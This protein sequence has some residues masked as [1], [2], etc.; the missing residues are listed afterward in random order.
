MAAMAC[1]AALAGA[2]SQAAGGAAVAAAAAASERGPAPGAAVA[3]LVWP[4]AGGR[5]LATG[6][7]G[8]KAVLLQWWPGALA[9]AGAAALV[10]VCGRRARAASRRERGSTQGGRGETR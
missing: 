6:Q 5:L 10:H 1:A 4:L 7:E 9:G 3:A 8:V 2:A